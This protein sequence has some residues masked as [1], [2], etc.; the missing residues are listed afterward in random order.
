M[1]AQHI[2]LPI[3]FACSMFQTAVGF[4]QVIAERKQGSERRAYFS[5]D[6]QFLD[7]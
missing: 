1:Q 7:V 4:C 3:S 2:L 5:P 6:S